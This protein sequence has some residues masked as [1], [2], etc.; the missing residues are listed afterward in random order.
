MELLTHHFKKLLRGTIILFGIAVLFIG[1]LII[2]PARY[3]HSQ[4]A[5]N[6]MQEYVRRTFHQPFRMISAMNYSWYEVHYKSTFVFIDRPDIWFNVGA[7]TNLNP[8]S[9][10]DNYYSYYF[11]AMAEEALTAEAQALWG[12]KLNN[13]RV[14]KLPVALRKLPL[15]EE[16]TLPEVNHLFFWD[17]WDISID[18]NTLFTISERETEA[19]RILAFLQIV[20]EQGYAQ[21]LHPPRI[22]VLYNDAQGNSLAYLT[23]FYWDEV[24]KREYDNLYW[25]EDIQVDEVLAYLNKDLRDNGYVLDN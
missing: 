5:I 1:V 7:P 10:G 2:Y 11:S 12:G 4:P 22:N 21:G 24:K 17:R 6:L 3:S 8:A 23:F 9:L 16:S 19:Q 14:A 13:V 20:K 15:N 25:N 18:Q